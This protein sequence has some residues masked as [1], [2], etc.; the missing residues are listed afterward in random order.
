M[1]AGQL[2]SYCV[3]NI[4]VLVFYVICTKRSSA[5]SNPS[6]FVKSVDTAAKL[7]CILMIYS[8]LELPSNVLTQRAP[9]TNFNHDGEGGGGLTEVHILYPKNHNFRICLPK[10]V[11]TFLSIP[12]KIPLFFFATQKIP[13]VFHRPKKTT[14]GQNLRP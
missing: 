3:N 13:G 11:T 4:I 10:K 2:D 8:V 9:L 1:F 12:K 6:F 5:I 7:Y 14:L